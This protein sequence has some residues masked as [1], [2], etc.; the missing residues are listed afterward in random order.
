VE[1]EAEAAAAP[2]HPSPSLV[3]WPDLPAVT[4]LAASRW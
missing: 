1:A 2:A 3:D 4:V